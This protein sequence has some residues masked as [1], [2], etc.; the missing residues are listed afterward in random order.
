MALEDLRELFDE[1]YIFLMFKL[2]VFCASL[3][4]KVSHSAKMVLKGSLPSRTTLGSTISCT[5]DQFSSWIL[6]FLI[7]RHKP[8]PSLETAWALL[9][10]SIKDQLTVK[11]KKTL[12]DC[13]LV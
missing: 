9:V 3:F 12:S 4:G 1:V 11:K 6:K 7:E 10:L 13:K 5:S 2:R 8:A